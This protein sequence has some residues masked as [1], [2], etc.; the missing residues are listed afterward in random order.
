MAQYYERYQNIVQLLNQYDGAIGDEDGVRLIVFK[1]E[2]INEATTD[3][4]ELTLA[5]KKSKE[6]V[7]AVGLLICDE[8]TQYGPMIRAFNNAFTTG[9]D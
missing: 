6:R 7:L 9:H 4:A 3:L 8:P 2:G 5:S 1:A